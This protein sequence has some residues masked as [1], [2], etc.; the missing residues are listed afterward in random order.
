MGNT[1]QSWF[2]ESHREYRDRYRTTVTTAQGVSAFLTGSQP[3]RNTLGAGYQSRMKDIEIPGYHNVLRLRKLHKHI[4]DLDLGHHMAQEKVSLSMPKS[5][6]ERAWLGGSTYYHYEGVF[7]PTVT[8]GQQMQAM[9]AGRSIPIPSDLGADYLYLVGLGSTAIKKSIP[10]VPDFSLP[11]FIG[12]LREGLP[13]IPGMAVRSERKLRSVGGEYLN[14]QFGVMPTVSDVQKLIELLFHPN[15]K[16]FI[17]RTLDKEFRVR[18]VLDK[19]SSYTTTD[20]SGSAEM[21]T[22]SGFVGTP[23]GNQRRTQSYRIW[24][25][26]TFKQLQVNRLQSLINDLE[27]QLGMGVVPTAIDLWNLV[28]WSWFVDW[29]TNLNHVITNLSYLE[30]NGLYLK[31]G[32]IMGTF[33][34]VTTVT[35]TRSIGGVTHTTTGTAHYVRKY[36]V[37]ASPFGFGLTWKDF[38]PFQ[39]SILGALGIS[40]LRF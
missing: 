12:E 13:K 24:S 34:D 14:Y 29:F 37:G 35:Q 16:A 2:G 28:P 3:P 17:E 7:V 30:K 25:S 27:R 10:D 21:N 8:Y 26:V 9:A 18:K 20:L 6:R 22:V 5:I 33:E 36:R 11:R 15:T 31:Y 40:R 38:D 32:Y 4:R 1:V 19:G 23:S 39:L